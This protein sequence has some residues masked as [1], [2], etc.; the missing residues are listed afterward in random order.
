VSTGGGSTTGGGS[1]TGGGASTGGG[2]TT[3]GGSATGGGALADFSFIRM[4]ISPD[5]GSQADFTVHG[6]AK[7]ANGELWAVFANGKVYVAPSGSNVLTLLPGQPAVPTVSAALIDVGV[8]T[9]GVFLLTLAGALACTTGCTTFADFN[10]AGTI[11][12]TENGQ[13]MCSNGN[14]VAFI[15]QDNS[16]TGL[17]TVSGGG[18]F[19]KFVADVGVT[20]GYSCFMAPNGDVYVPGDD[21][22]IAVAY[23]AGGLGTQAIALGAN[24][25]A[26]WR[27]VTIGAAGGFVVGGGSGLR[28]AVKAGSTWNDLVPD[29]SGSLMSAVVTAGNEVYAGQFTNSS[30]T[31]APALFKWNGSRFVPLP[32]QP[33]P[34]FDVTSAL[35]V[36]ANELY[37]AGTERAFGGFIVM[38][39]T[40]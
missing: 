32:T 37:F 2:T 39:G 11:T 7:R 21:S 28:A 4:S 30:G 10:P 15:T 16:L 9:T 25:T 6:L 20:R 18:S 17:W 14:T 29:T 22:A 1:S 36:S 3:G 27:S 5:P 31:T 26:S 40:R 34:A 24:P 12:G 8:T 33:T 19:S 38:H 35:G 13:A 23:G